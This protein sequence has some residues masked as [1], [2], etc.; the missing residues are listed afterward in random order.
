MTEV[1]E[2]QVGS[3]EADM[4]LLR[5]GNAILESERDTNFKRRVEEEIR[6]VKME[7]E[8]FGSMVE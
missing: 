6:T 4:Q 5:D 2:V 3:V 7:V 8:R 1:V